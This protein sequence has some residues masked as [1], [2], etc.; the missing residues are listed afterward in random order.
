MKTERTTALDNTAVRFMGT[1]TSLHQKKEVTLG[2]IWEKTPKTEDYI[3]FIR[4]AL[5]SSPEEMD[6][7]A[8]LV[9]GL[10]AC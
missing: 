8:Q 4:N 7:V 2:T 5:G 9:P 6:E 1:N 10:L 3:A